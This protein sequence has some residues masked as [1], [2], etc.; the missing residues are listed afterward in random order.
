MTGSWLSQDRPV[1][2]RA[3]PPALRPAGP[4]ASPPSL[5]ASAG[6]RHPPGRPPLSLPLSVT[7]SP[8]AVS[9]SSARVLVLG[10]APLRSCRGG[11]GRGAQAA[12][13]Q[14]GIEAPPKQQRPG[15]LF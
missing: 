6:L 15:N 10:V 4:G 7:P 8:V 13:F 11:L 9:L 3:W 1:G 5:A 2:A 14:R 12:G